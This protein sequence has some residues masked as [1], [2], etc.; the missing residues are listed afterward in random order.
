MHK[1][2]HDEH[3]LTNSSA[4]KHWKDDETLL[5]TPVCTSG[6]KFT[7][8]L[9]QLKPQM[10]RPRMF[11]RDERRTLPVNTLTRTDAR[12]LRRG[13]SSRTCRSQRSAPLNRFVYLSRSATVNFDSWPDFP[14]NEAGLQL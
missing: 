14:N 4:L 13:C 1:T 3:T 7:R 11:R 10:V 8:S 9:A 5:L 6:S 2:I 12:P